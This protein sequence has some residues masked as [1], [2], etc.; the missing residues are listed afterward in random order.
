[1]PFPFA[2]VV[3]RQK[4]KREKKKIV[5]KEKTFHFNLFLLRNKLMT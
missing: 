1:M 3:G 4:K 5:D 2:L